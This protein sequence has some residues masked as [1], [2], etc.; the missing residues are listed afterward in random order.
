M[1][2][3]RMAVFDIDWTLFDHHQGGFT[4]SA[5]RA[6]FAAKKN[7]VKIVIASGRAYH[8]IERIGALDAI[9]YDAVIASNGACIYIGKK[10]VYQRPL[11]K[12]AM[13]TLMQRMNQHQI[14]V[15]LIT[16][17]GSFINLPRNEAMNQIYFHFPADTPPIIAYK[18]QTVLTG[19][20]FMSASNDHLI[21]DLPFDFHRFHEQ[22]VDIFD[23]ENHKGNALLKTCEFL[24]INIEACIA[25]GDD[26]N[27]I[28]M[29]LAAGVGVAMGNAKPQLL[30]VADFITHPIEQDGI[31]FALK[32]YEVI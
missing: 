22:G 8:L 4:P 14:L 3:I 17:R 19:I 11:N 7:G 2:K 5:L 30:E 26:T 6:I 21:Q 16:A 20:L 18:N 9:P 29:L 23:K 10:C 1:T 24:H 15:E 12:E 13:A 31:E 28:E 32:K 25:F 27:D